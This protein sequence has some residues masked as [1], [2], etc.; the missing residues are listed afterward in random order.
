MYDV[1][2]AANGLVMRVNSGISGVDIFRC[3][4]GEFSAILHTLQ[5]GHFQDP[6]ARHD[7]LVIKNTYC[8]MSDVHSV[9]LSSSLLAPFSCKQREW[10]LSA[11]DGVVCSP[12]GN[13]KRA[14]FACR[15][16]D[17]EGDRFY[18]TK[19]HHLRI[20][21]H[22]GTAMPKKRKYQKSVPTPTLQA[23]KLQKRALEALQTRTKFAALK[24][25][26]VHK[27]RLQQEPLE[28]D[29]TQTVATQQGHYQQQQH[30]QQHQQI[31]CFGEFDIKWAPQSSVG[32]NLHYRRASGIDAACDPP[33]SVKDDAN[34][35]FPARLMPQDVDDWKFDAVYGNLPMFAKDPIGTRE[36]SI[37]TLLLSG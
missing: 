27:A 16:C 11:Y 25:V 36:S 8:S 14:M 28:Q 32:I 23:Q 30:Q 17:Y 9:S 33:D 1:Q 21:V 35:F 2:F 19:N 5:P 29:K 6:R 24:R 13:R 34:M 22:K 12:A 15:E 3:Y 10:S 4:F 20:H 26:P 37:C 7:I 18:H 31:L